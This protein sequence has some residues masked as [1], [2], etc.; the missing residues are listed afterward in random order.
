L[1]RTGPGL[2]P[3]RRAVPADP[4]RAAADRDL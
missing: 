2:P 4:G 3:G 1:S